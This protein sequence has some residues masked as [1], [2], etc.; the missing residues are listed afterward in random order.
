MSTFYTRPSNGKRLKGTRRQRREARARKPGPA[1]VV[2]RDA[3]ID[4]YHI[5]TDEASV[6]LQRL[7][8]ARLDPRSGDARQGWLPVS[9]ALAEEGHYWSVGQACAREFPDELSAIA[10]ALV[11]E[12]AGVLRI[13]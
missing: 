1:W 9:H 11:N 8:L 13:R 5:K 7:F 3:P 10:A 2:Y 12:P 4:L 6:A